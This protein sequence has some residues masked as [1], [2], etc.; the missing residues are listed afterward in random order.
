[1]RIAIYNGLVL[2]LRTIIDDVIPQGAKIATPAFIDA[3][4]NM[5]APN[6]A[7]VRALFDALP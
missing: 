2:E 6:P 1:M 5:T 3:L 7:A 4:E